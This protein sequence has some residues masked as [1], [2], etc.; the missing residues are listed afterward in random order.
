MF[1]S[2]KTRFATAARRSFDLAL[3]FATLGEY[4]LPAEVE[5]VEVRRSR[6]AERA[7][8]GELRVAADG[9][10]GGAGRPRANRLRPATAAGR[11]LQPE[12]PARRISSHSGVRALAM[13]AGEP[14]P[15]RGGRKRAGAARPTPQPC[16]V[17]DSGLP[18]AVDA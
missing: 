13:A 7:S 9:V 17:G 2:V 8:A 5:P 6:R 12:V 18:R 15:L 4:R 10:A 16:L 14:R 3:E 11:R 1:P